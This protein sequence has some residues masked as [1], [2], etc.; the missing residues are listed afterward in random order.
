MTFLSETKL[1]DIGFSSLGE[2]VFLS[3]KASVYGAERIHIGSNVRID[4]FVVLSAGEGGIYIGNYVHIAFNSSLIGKARIEMKDFSGL[5]AR[6]S[7]Y[8]S[9]DDYSGQFMTNPCVPEE[10]R[11]VFSADVIIGEHSIVGASSIVLPGICIGKAC[12]IGAQSLVKEDCRS[13]GVYAGSPA[14]YIKERSR[15]LLELEQ[16]LKKQAR[17]I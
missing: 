4:D 6:V 5:S 14:K 15:E 11:N 16:N 9:N 2:N 8:S 10:Y 17:K 3:D 12:A 1:R 13:F 7:I